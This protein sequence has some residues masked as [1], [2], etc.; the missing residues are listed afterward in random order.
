MEIVK[1]LG[2]ALVMILVFIVSFLLLDLI[3]K[4]SSNE[5]V[6]ALLQ[7][8]LIVNVFVAVI[9]A[10]FLVIYYQLAYN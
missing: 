9:A 4:R 8:K 6:K 10:I 3:E 7:K 1:T 5:K 2:A